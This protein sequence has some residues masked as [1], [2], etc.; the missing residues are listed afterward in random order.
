MSNP[1]ATAPT[2]AFKIAD[3]FIYI[4]N[5][6]HSFLSNLK[7]QKLVYYAQAWHLAF[8]DTPLFNEDFEAWG[9]GSVIPALF[10]EYQKFSFKPIEKEVEEPHFPE[11]LQEFLDKIV[12][13]YFFRDGYELELM[14]CEEEPWLA[15]RGDLPKDQ[16][17]NAPIT[18]ESMRDYYLAIES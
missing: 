16:D 14:V 9:H 3:Y 5:D 2:T 11:E 15:A 17:A 18:K 1:T 6:T 13:D 10:E 12:D 4:A 8:Y 7:L